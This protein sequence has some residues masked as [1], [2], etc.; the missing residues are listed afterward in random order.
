MMVG[1]V[2]TVERSRSEAAAGW[3]W[4]LMASEEDSRGV[5]YEGADWE[6]I[7]LTSGNLIPQPLG[8]NG[9]DLIEETLVG[10]AY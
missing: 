3:E 4:C 9:S 10:A 1:A 6:S 7:P 8:R 5:R 2:R